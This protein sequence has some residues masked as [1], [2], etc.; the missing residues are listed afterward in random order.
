MFTDGLGALAADCDA[1]LL[2]RDG[3]RQAIRRSPAAEQPIYIASVGKVLAALTVGVLVDQ[4]RIQGVHEPLANWFPTWRESS[5]ASITLDHVLSHRSGIQ[6]ATDAVELEMAHDVVSLAL[7]SPLSETPG[8]VARYNNKAFALIAGLVRNVSGL[9]F[10]R[11]F[12]Q[13]IGEP[14]RIGHHQWFTDGTGTPATYGAFSTLPDD[15]L[16]LGSLFIGHSEPKC[17]A[18][19]SREWLQYMC[20]P[21]G[22][23][24]PELCHP[25]HRRVVGTTGKST[26]VFFHGGYRGNL[27]AVIPS[28]NIVL[29]RMVTAETFAAGHGALDFTPQLLEWCAGL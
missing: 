5:H 13:A 23:D 11:F 1:L 16:T 17:A 27:L 10:D 22:L 19:I 15:L 2:L 12:E 25:W 18:V 24:T 26:E 29:L 14:L 6:A 3:Q 20:T 28:K 4:G 8:L 7:R 9:R 21:S